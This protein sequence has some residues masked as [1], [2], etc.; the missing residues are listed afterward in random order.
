[1]VCTQ[2]ITISQV[3]AVQIRLGKEVVP[4]VFDYHWINRVVV[5]S[6]SVIPRVAAGHARPHPRGRHDVVIIVRGDVFVISIHFWG[7]I[8]IYAEKAN[9][10]E[11]HKFSGIVFIRKCR[12][13]V[14]NRLEVDVRVW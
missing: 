10:E 8:W 2:W 9:A 12:F 7:T 1:M 6:L 14:A 11:L 4:I 3:T 5:G 13:C